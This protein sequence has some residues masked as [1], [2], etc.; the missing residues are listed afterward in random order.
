M[1][2]SRRPPYAK[3]QAMDTARLD[4]AAKHK[5]G[6]PLISNSSSPSLMFTT[7][8]K[9]CDLVLPARSNIDRL[10]DRLV[11]KL[12]GDAEPKVKMQ[13]SRCPAREPVDLDFRANGNANFG[14]C[15]RGPDWGT[16]SDDQT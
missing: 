3:Q 14:V 7:K 11:A 12:E 10:A 16:V 1:R 9:P 15:E 13:D 5:T 4:R 2:D 6:K 8:A